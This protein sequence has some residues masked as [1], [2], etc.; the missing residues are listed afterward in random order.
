LIW[1]TFFLH[2]AQSSLIDVRSD[3]SSK[4]DCQRY[5]KA[6]CCPNTPQRN[7]PRE[8]LALKMDEPDDGVDCNRPDRS[9]IR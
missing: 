9:P 2:G 6:K 8:T 3:R 7:V 1:V 5:F 4:S